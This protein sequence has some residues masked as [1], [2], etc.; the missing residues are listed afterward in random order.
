M[1]DWK[2]KYSDSPVYRLNNFIR[3]KLDSM[4]F[5]DLE[6]YKTDLPGGEF[7]L[8]FMIP[9]QDIPEMVTI[10]DEAKYNSLPYCVYSVSDRLNADEPYMTCGQATY[11]F[12]H[13]DMDYLIG[14][15]DYLSELLRREDWTAFDV[16]DHFKSD[17]NYAFDFKYISL[18]T[19]AG[20]AP[21]DEEGGRSSMLVVIRYD[22]TYEGTGRNYTLTPGY[23]KEFG[24][25]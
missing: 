14:M 19:T 22:V 16:N 3:D 2:I 24:M 10:Y 8:P 18:L 1:T 9:G 20:P 6:K 11:T 4:E 25:R 23:S 5:I 12:Y 7:A 13:L 15:K 17:V 21:V